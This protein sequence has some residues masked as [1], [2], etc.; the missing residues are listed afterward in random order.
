MIF[1]ICLLPTVGAAHCFA[2][3][4]NDSLGTNVLL[5]RKG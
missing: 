3:D 1:G 4:L 5:Q 2:S